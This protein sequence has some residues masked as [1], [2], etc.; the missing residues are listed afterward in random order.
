MKKIIVIMLVFCIMLTLGCGAKKDGSV[1]VDPNAGTETAEDTKQHAAAPGAVVADNEED[2]LFFE[3]DGIK[4]YTYDMAEDVLASLGKPNGTFEADSCAYQGK[5]VFYYY[6]GFQLTVNDVDDADHVTVIMVVDDTVSIPQGVKIGDT[7]EEMLQAM[8]D[9]YTESSGLY[10]FVS[11]N[12]TLQIQ[13]KEGV[14][15]SM[16]YVYTPQQ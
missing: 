2:K 3:S 5:D 1:V 11:G 4:I 8:G 14:V 10:Q 7:E 16:L 13:I 6:N 12:T 9:D 15:A